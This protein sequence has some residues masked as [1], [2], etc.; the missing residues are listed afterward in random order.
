MNCAAGRNPPRRSLTRV[1]TGARSA[2]GA[3]DLIAQ[4]AGGPA[5]KR[6]CDRVHT[7]STGNDRTTGSADK[8]ALKVVFK[9]CRKRE[10]PDDSQ[11]KTRFEHILPPIFV[12]LLG[13]DLPEPSGLTTEIFSLVP[14]TAARR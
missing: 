10:Q 6:P 4:C 3:R 13:A 7:D 1:K 14:T 5:D 9:T 8:T 2:A 11:D 12:F